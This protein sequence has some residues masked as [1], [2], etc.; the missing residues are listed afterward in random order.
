[1]K[2]IVIYQEGSSPIVVM[3]NDDKPLDEYSREISK[4]LESNNISILH[5]STCST[6][7]RPN[8]I[9]SI[10]VSDTN[11]PDKENVIGQQEIKKEEKEEIQEDIISD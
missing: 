11:M 7:L 2:Q 4:L 1:M 9:S 3:D 5:T 8:K 10:S 6:I